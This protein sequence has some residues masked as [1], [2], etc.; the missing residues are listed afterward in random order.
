MIPANAAFVQALTPIK[1][2]IQDFKGNPIR[3][4]NFLQYEQIE[5]QTKPS[6]TVIV[7]LSE[8]YK[9]ARLEIKKTGSNNF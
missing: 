7:I 5:C 9:N 3:V 4:S 2:H 8:V 1:Y 6:K